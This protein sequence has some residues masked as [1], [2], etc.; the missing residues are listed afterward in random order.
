MLLFRAFFWMS[1]FIFDYVNECTSV[2]Q[3]S[4][5]ESR[6]MLGVCHHNL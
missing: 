5:A 2:S 6:L 4:M 3:L 1:S